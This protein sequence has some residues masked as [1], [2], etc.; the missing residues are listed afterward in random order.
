MRALK[1]VG[2]LVVVTLGGSLPSLGQ[3]MPDWSTGSPGA[4][5]AMVALDADHNAYVVGTR[6][7][8]VMLIT[9]MDSTGAQVWQRS[10]SGAGLLTRGTAVAADATGNTVVAGTVVTS[11]GQPAG[12][13]VLKFDAAGTLLWQDVTAASQGQTRRV[14][15]DRAGNAYVLGLAPSPVV[16]GLDMVVVKY[17]VAGTR[18]WSRSLA[19]GMIG[20]DAMAFSPSGLIV[21]TGRSSGGQISLVAVDAAGTAAAPRAFAA[22]S[23]ASDLAIGPDGSLYVVGGDVAGGGFLVAKFSSSFT[24]V[25]RNTYPAR[26][27]AMRAALDSA[28]NL[29]V[30]G[31]SD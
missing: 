19:S 8:P 14:L 12:S 11:A 28:G 22:S 3:T 30:T 13:V 27:V 20:A 31:P 23:E 4:V 17:D 29:L 21:A 26:G 7:G 10:F 16:S 15:I 1:R 25:W 24:E 6:S 18:Q 2:L 5:G 9:R